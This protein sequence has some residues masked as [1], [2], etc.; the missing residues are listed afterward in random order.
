MPRNFALMRLN[1]PNN[2]IINIIILKVVAKILDNAFLKKIPHLPGDSISLFK[3]D[4]S[5]LNIMN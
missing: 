3:R 4:K 1:V 2:T 5:F